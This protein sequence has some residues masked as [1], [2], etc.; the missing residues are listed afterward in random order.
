MSENQTRVNVVGIEN[1]S[2]ANQRELNKQNPGEPNDNK[3]E[4]GPSETTRFWRL[5]TIAALNMMDKDERVEIEMWRTP[6][7]GQ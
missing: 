3:P 1:E 6:V 2:T 5:N 4:R 7:L